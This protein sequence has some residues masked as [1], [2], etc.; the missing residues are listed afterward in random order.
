M[1]ENKLIFNP[2]VSVVGLY[3]RVS[4]K[5]RDTKMLLVFHSLMVAM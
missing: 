2:S 1:S 4:V 3:S 5:I